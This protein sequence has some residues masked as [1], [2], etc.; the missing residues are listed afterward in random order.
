MPYILLGSP[1]LFDRF[2]LN[3]TQCTH[4]CTQT[5]NKG[6]FC[7]LAFDT[8]GQATTC[9]W[10]Q[11]LW[12]VD[13]RVSM[14]PGSIVADLKILECKKCN[15][16]YTYIK[17]LMKM[18]NQRVLS[19]NIWQKQIFKNFRRVLHQP[20]VV[21]SLTFEHLGSTLITRHTLTSGTIITAA[22]SAIDKMQNE[23]CR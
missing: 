9:V 4:T 19:F 13:K 2:Y 11:N 16:S 7:S 3:H 10:H 20:H 6:N 1:P 18:K 8:E 23:P 5:I 21:F 12:C 17:E 22:L 14:E 15:S